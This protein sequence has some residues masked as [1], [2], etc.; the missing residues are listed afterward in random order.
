MTY[1]KANKGTVVV[2]GFKGRLRLRWSYQGRRYTLSL[3]LPDN[4]TNRKI[5]ETKARIIERDMAAENF[6]ATLAR[7][8]PQ[9]QAGENVA[10]V[11]L[12][13]RFTQHKS[14]QVLEQSLV[15]YSGLE[16][17]LRQYFRQKPAEQITE[18]EAAK[19]K[20]WL[21][22]RVKP[23]TLR[24]RISLLKACW[25]W[26]LRKHW[27]TTNPWEDL[28]VKVSRKRPDAFTAEEV[29]L[30]VEGFREQAPHYVDYV[31]FVLG[32]GCRLGE[33]IA[34]RWKHLNADCS[35]VWIV[36]SYYRGQFKTT[37]TEEDRFFEL[38]PRLRGMLQAR[39]GD[40]KPEDLVFPAPKGGPI[41]DHNFRNRYWKPILDKLG[42]RYRKPRNVRQTFAS[43]ALELGMSPGEVSAITGHSIETLYRNY[44]GNVKSRP[45]VP[46]L[47]DEG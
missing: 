47:W 28:S 7:Y 13:Q 12:F 3:E 36:D 9:G 43:H 16:G 34:L 39:R 4:L 25:K 32:V 45:Q 44:A 10:A 20:D 21:G 29:R 6:D 19:F 27:V 31:E 42:V 35:V 40:A 5:A 17:Y 24:E 46:T 8:R 11:E 15:K 1:Q 41:D 38:S 33:A 30:I 22:K 14:K 2:F 23:I 18:A 26:A 37:K